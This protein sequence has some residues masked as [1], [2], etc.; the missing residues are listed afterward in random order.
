MPQLV[1]TSAGEPYYIPSPNESVG[2]PLYAQP[3]QQ[4]NNDLQEY[5]KSLPLPVEAPPL[6]THEPYVPTTGQKVLQNLT[7]ADGAER[8]Q[9]WPEKMVRNAVDAPNA[10]LTGRVAPGSEQELEGALDLAGM[11]GLGLMKPTVKG[12][13]AEQPNILNRAKS[14]MSEKPKLTPVEGN[15]FSL[16]SD[17]G[18]LA[19]VVALAKQDKLGFIHAVDIALPKIEMKSGTAEQ[20]TNA[21]KRYGVGKEELE[22]SVGELPK[23]NITKE[24]FLQHVN[25]NKVQLQEH[26]KGD[27]KKELPEGYKVKKQDDG[28]YYVESPNGKTNKA[29][30]R[31]PEAA[32]DSMLRNI[33]NK[34]KYS[35][36]Q[37]PGGE[38]YRELVLTL[39][40][41]DQSSWQLLPKN[42]GDISGLQ[43][44]FKNRQEAYDYYQTLSK[45]QQYGSEIGPVRKGPEYTNSHWD[46][47]NVLAHVRMNDR[48]IPGM[49]KS[50]H[51]EEAQSDIHQSA[52]KQG[53][54]L[55]EKEIYAMK[56][57]LENIRKELSNPNTSKER[58]IELYER[59]GKLTD[60]YNQH[61][62]ALPNFP[63]KRN[64]DELALKKMLIE[65]AKNG[66]DA[67]SWTPGRLQSTNPSQHVRE[68]KVT[69]RDGNY[70]M[71]A[72]DKN[73]Y[74]KDFYAHDNKELESI[75]GKEIADK[76]INKSKTLPEYKLLTELPEEYHLIHNAHGAK[77]GQ[78][79]GIISRG[80]QHAGSYTGRYHATQEEAIK[81]ALETI[82]HGRKEK[83]VDENRRF[84]LNNVDLEIGG[85]KHF[86]D[87][88]LVNKANKLVKQYGGKVEEQHLPADRRAIEKNFDQTRPDEIAI[89]KHQG[90]W[91]KLVAE[92]K[93]LTSITEDYNH[94]SK[95]TDEYKKA[96]TKL[97]D[98]DFAM[99]GIH[100]Q[101]VKE[102][103]QRMIESGK[104]EKVWTIKLT[105]ELKAKAKEGFSLFSAPS[106]IPVDHDPF[107]TRQRKL[108]PV[109]FNPFSNKDL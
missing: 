81:Q 60:K 68:I 11:G 30:W 57:E 54:K 94:R 91:D 78:E 71:N 90:E 46:E 17:T 58:Q 92:R 79:W 15:P 12:M 108:Y 33:T 83:F 76:I 82:N 35:S 45:D 4:Q 26:W 31:T 7:G 96:A 10:A 73:G 95:N 18:K 16:K 101:M 48:Q 24:Q 65:A 72:I 88:D 56:N 13:V 23:G 84:E 52:R 107:A 25:E 44:K 74:G 9:F 47:P 99:E 19:P 61:H 89:A 5:V 37:M 103:M 38:N 77:K 1:Y 36:Y 28:T 109:S 42:N 20:W 34:S 97:G 66:Y 64:W 43:T 49:G 85:S 39:P 102:T 51:I 100:T 69:N 40:S 67:I 86:Y 93:K 98:I 21:L 8:F 106:I 3:T 6:P 105:P 63:F 14:L 50:L 62:D 87:F 32:I 29:A 80:Q 75:V 41:R 104:G 2:N 27:L 22:W 53:Y 70:H 59:E 55:P